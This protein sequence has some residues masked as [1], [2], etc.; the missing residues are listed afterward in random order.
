MSEKAC[1]D[2]EMPEYPDIRNYADA[3][4]E[5]ASSHPLRELTIFHPFLLRTVTPPASGFTGRKLERVYH[6]GKRIVLQFEEEYFIV[7]HLMVA[8][9]LHWKDGAPAL[10]DTGRMAARSGGVLARVHFDNGTLSLTEAGSK[11]R[12]ALYLVSGLPEL[13]RL[14]PGGVDV[15]S[16]EAD[17]FHGILVS[18]NHTL[19]RALTDP[20]L[21]SGIG[22]A[23][24]DEILFAARMPP[25]RLTHTLAPSESGRLLD[26]ARATLSWW[27]T[28]LRQERGGNFPRKVS[29]FH[30]LMRV[31]GKYNQ[32]CTIC[33]TPI[34][35]IRYAE[36]ECNYCPACQN[37]GRVYADRALSRLLKGEWPKTVEELER[38]P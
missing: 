1:Y 28:H 7:L 18:E 11:R 34:Q 16:T 10:P 25:L 21:V 15:F 23:Y 2:V 12:A 14:D 5:R 6:I 17:A 3:I 22:N 13:A 9:R 38:L 19:K 35:R 32:Q 8:G 37:E 4:A 31:H 24:S 33:S 27:E 26:A 20:R 29:A 36:N 30:P